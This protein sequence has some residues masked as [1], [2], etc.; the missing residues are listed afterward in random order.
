MRSQEREKVRM[1]CLRSVDRRMGAKS[2]IWEREEKRGSVAFVG[3]HPYPAAVT[4]HHFLADGQPDTGA[5]KFGAGMQPFKDSE[6]LFVKLLRN[7]DA[8]IADR[9][10][11]E[12]GMLFRRD[13]NQRWRFTAVFQG[14]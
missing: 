10:T 7:T 9:K 13:T 12:S 5:G 4:L 8:V 14:I 6:Y 3:L 11:P 1:E 2:L